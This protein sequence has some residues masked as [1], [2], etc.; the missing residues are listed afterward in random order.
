M[1]VTNAFVKNKHYNLDTNNEM[2]S[3][4]LFKG[5]MKMELLKFTEFNFKEILFT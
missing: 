5:N 4:K 1:K 3:Y 2:K